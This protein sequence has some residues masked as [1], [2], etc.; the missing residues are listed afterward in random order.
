LPGFEVPIR[1]GRNCSG[2]GIIFYHTRFVN[3]IRRQDLEHG[4]LL[5]C[6]WFIDNVFSWETGV[7]CGPGFNSISPQTINK[8][9]TNR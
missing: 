5:E 9:N 6:M 1:R 4:D 2:G 7:P 8:L 3:V